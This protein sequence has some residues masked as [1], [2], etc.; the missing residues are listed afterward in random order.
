MC[1]NAK[2]KAPVTLSPIL[3]TGLSVHYDLSTGGRSVRCH[4]LCQ[5][6]HGERRQRHA[7]QSGQRHQIP[8]QPQHSAQRHQTRKPAGEFTHRALASGERSYNFAA[9]YPPSF[10]NEQW[11]NIT[12][13]GDEMTHPCCPHTSR[14]FLLQPP[15]F[16]PSLP[17]S[18]FCRPPS[19][20]L[21]PF[22]PQQLS[23]IHPTFARSLPP[24]VANCEWCS[25]QTLKNAPLRC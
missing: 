25:S 18:P 17:P 6:I 20:L 8:P 23:S 11:S 5:Q 2:Q 15:S 7:L 24:R 22:S 1:E 9:V 13:S 3:T 21:L 19:C 10:L 16:V 14:T 12:H 4:H